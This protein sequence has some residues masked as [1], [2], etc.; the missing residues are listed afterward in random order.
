MRYLALILCFLLSGCF[1]LPTLRGTSTN[2]D[3]VV[4]VQSKIDKVDDK[5]QK[6]EDSQKKVAA[7]YAAGVQHSLL[8][9]TNAP[10]QVKTAISLNERVISILG[11]PNLSELTKINLTV[12]L[13]NSSVKEERLRGEFELRQKDEQIT[14]IQK[15]HEKLDQERDRR[16]NDLK[17]TVQ[18]VSLKAD[19]GEAVKKEMSKWGG[20]G[21][22]IWGV[23][24]FL[25][26]VFWWVIGI[27]I[28]FLL[29]RVGA[30]AWPP[31]KL[32]MGIFDEIGALFV[33]GA[34]LIG[35]AA[36]EAAGVVSCSVHDKYK[37]TLIKLI[38]IYFEFVKAGKDT[39]GD[40]KVD[41][42]DFSELIEKIDAEDVKVI[43][44]IREQYHL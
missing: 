26:R 9:V 24:A 22:I 28:V 38:K 33:R 37:T 40:G 2:R 35:P 6:N 14:K 5:I 34:K 39:N 32:I 8:D 31:L 42:S 29:L 41:F 3:K 43:N 17:K 44:E 18:S 30:E 10:V 13:L 12:D 16:E 4:A 23:K 11:E 25:S 27:C 15:D 19:E 21:A 7:T 36:Y 20:I 1:E